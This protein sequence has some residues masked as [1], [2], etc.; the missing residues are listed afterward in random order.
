MVQGTDCE[1]VIKFL[2][3]RAA[4]L[5]KKLTFIKQSYYHNDVTKLQ[6]PDF[7]FGTFNFSKLVTIIAES[8]FV[9]LDND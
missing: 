6:A 1:M 8:P 9:N 4:K 2:D 3:L 7:T 5:E